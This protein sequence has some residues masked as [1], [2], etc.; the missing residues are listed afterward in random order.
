MRVAVRLLNSI[1]CSFLLHDDSFLSFLH[2]LLCSICH[3]ILLR[4][5]SSLANFKRNFQSCQDLYRFLRSSNVIPY[6]PWS[7][8][9]PFPRSPRNRQAIS[10]RWKL[11]IAA[12]PSNH[13]FLLMLML[14]FLGTPWFL[15]SPKSGN[16]CFERCFSSISLSFQNFTTQIPTRLLS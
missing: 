16:Q 12:W 11:S 7:H 1:P 6:H 4:F 2:I 9:P 8:L 3:S 13:W 5:Q 15:V 10:L 14:P